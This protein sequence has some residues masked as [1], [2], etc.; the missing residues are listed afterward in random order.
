MEA[1]WEGRLALEPLCFFGVAAGVGMKEPCAEAARWLQQPASGARGC[2]TWVNTPAGSSAALRCAAGGGGPCLPGGAA[3][4]AGCGGGGGGGTAA[5]M[6]QGGGAGGQG[7][8]A[9]GAGAAGGV[10][11][12]AGIHAVAACCTLLVH[13]RATVRA[14]AGAFTHS[15]H[16]LSLPHMLLGAGAAGKGRRALPALHPVGRLPV[17]DGR[18]CAALHAGAIPQVCVPGA[19]PSPCMALAS[20]SICS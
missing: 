14:P 1:N 20:A 2:V 18:G 19:L 16:A 8:G 3:P 15:T 10:R 11:A 7:G 17:A 12:A 4:A 13:E 6:Q 5:A 9:A